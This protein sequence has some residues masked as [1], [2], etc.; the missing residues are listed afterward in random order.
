MSSL[1]MWIEAV[2][3]GIA[4]SGMLLVGR[5]AALSPYVRLGLVMGGMG[6]PVLGW[7]IAAAATS[8]VHASFAM[9]ADVAVLCIAGLVVQLVA[10]AVMGLD[11]RGWPSASRAVTAWAMAGLLLAMTV[12]NTDL[13]VRQRMAVLR[14][15]AGAAILSVAPPRPA[16]RDNAAPLYEQAADAYVAA[17][18][19][20]EEAWYGWVSTAKDLATDTRAAGVAQHLEANA[21]AL[22]LVRRAARLPGCDFGHSIAQLGPEM[23][24]PEL[25]SLRKLARLLALAA[26]AHAQAGEGDLALVDT[27]AIMALSAHAAGGPALI[28]G[29]VGIACERTAHRTLAGVALDQAQAPRGWRLPAL[30]DAPLTCRQQM[31]RSL[32]A[33]QA[34]GLAA[35]ANLVS[36]DD[37][38]LYTGTTRGE[39]TLLDGLSSAVASPGMV[40]WRVFY[41]EPDLASYRQALTEVISRTTG[42]PDAVRAPARVEETP[43]MLTRMLMP[44]LEQVLA[45]A[46]RVDAERELSRVALRCLRHRAG[47][48]A[49]P[50]TLTDL[51]G[52]TPL[53]PFDRKPLRMRAV[54]PCELVLYSVGSDGTDDGGKPVG[55][56]DA[57]GPGDLVLTLAVPAR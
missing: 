50:G 25:A 4:W 15:E 1:L 36:A 48:G 45:T 12:W 16:D 11:G 42:T 26:R 30:E 51:D 44:A 17:T 40:A 31:R 43:G 2:V 52:P 3:C 5:R 9:G 33:E 21:T 27:D 47:S 56:N 35:F 46:R 37:F 38:D 8:Y 53:D 29:L 24:L 10:L 23:M 14:T 57:N 7:G 39:R 55:P 6:L 28:H 34:F 20:E 49:F 19:E 32:H 54:G 41:L 13:A 18:P 22:E